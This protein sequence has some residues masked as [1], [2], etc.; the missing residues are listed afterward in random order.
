MDWSVSFSLIFSWL[1]QGCH[2]LVDDD[3]VTCPALETRMESAP[4]K[5]S[6]PRLREWMNPLRGKKKSRVLLPEKGEIIKKKI[7][8]RNKHCMMGGWGR[9]IF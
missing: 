5:A 8:Q 9:D 1:P 6:G 2:V 3:Y 7:Q 4:A